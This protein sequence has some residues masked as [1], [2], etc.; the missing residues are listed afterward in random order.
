MSSNNVEREVVVNIYDNT[1]AD[2][3]FN[4]LE[5]SSNF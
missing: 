3:R 4:E 1:M 2:H 5:I